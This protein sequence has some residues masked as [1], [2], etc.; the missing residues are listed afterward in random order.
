MSTFSKFQAAFEFPCVITDF[1]QKVICDYSFSPSDLKAN[2]K[3]M[4][5]WS[6]KL[7]GVLKG[8]GL[9]PEDKRLARISLKAC[10]VLLTL[11]YH[12]SKNADIL[13]SSDDFIANYPEFAGAS[14]MEVL[15]RYRNIIAVSLTLLEADNNKTKHMDIAVRLSEGKAAKYVTGSGQT[16]ATTRRVAIFERESGTKPK[17]AAE[18]KRKEAD[19]DSSEGSTKSKKSCVACVSDSNDDSSVSSHGSATL[20]C[21]FDEWGAEALDYL[22]DDLYF[23]EVLNE[24]SLDFFMAE[25]TTKQRPLCASLPASAPAVKSED[26]R[27]VCAATSVGAKLPVPTHDAFELDMQLEEMDFSE[28]MIFM[29]SFERN[30]PQRASLPAAVVPVSDVEDFDADGPLDFA[31]LDLMV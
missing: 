21:P 28:Q 2:L 25:D 30:M 10:F 1:I 23:D 4:K 9:C 20:T 29:D 17:K 12:E 27:T 19:S 24:D 8:S 14:D 13:Y 15:R 22:L 11:E 5:N 26:A 16:S 7:N 6:L 31:L 18:R 3:F